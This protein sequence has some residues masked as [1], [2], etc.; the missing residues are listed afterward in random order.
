[1][2]IV[3]LLVPALRDLGRIQEYWHGAVVS[4]EKITDFLS[5]QPLA[6]VP[7]TPL[8]LRPGPGELRFEN[9]RIS[10]S[11]ANFSASVPAGKIVALAGPNGA[12]KFTLLS[13]A[14]RLTDLEQGAIYLDGQDIRKLQSTSFHQAVGVMSPDLPLPRGSIQYNLSYRWRK[15]PKQELDRV[16]TLCAV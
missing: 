8:I 14:A 3:G 13:L 2:S 12:G 9:V 4:R 7:E 5:I 1:M 16:R 10:T 15:A 6:S 11:A